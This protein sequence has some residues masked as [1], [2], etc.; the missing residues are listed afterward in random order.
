MER[1]CAAKAVPHPDGTDETAGRAPWA[2]YG[3]AIVI[4]AA[5]AG[6]ARL[7]SLLF[8]EPTNLVMVFLLAVT[9]TATRHGAGPSVLAALLGVAVFDFFF[10][11]PH[12]TFA[13]KDTQY[14]FTFLVLLIVGL[15]ISRLTAQVRREAAVAQRA[16]IEAEG[17]RLRSSLLASVSHDLRTPL[18]TIAGSAE[19][20]LQ[21]GP[22]AGDQ[23]EL[24]A[25]IRDEAQRLSRYVEKLIAMTR[26]E[27]GSVALKKEWQPIE[28]AIGAAI[29]RVDRELGHREV[30]TDVPSE[31]PLVAIDAPLIEQVIV[32]LLENACR[33][34]GPDAGILI[35]ARAEAG[36]IVVEVAD[37]GQGLPPGSERRV[38]E[39]FHRE[40]GAGSGAGLGLAICM[41]VVLAHG[42]TMW[43]A[44]RLDGGASFSFVLPL[45]GTPPRMPA[46][47]EDQ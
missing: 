36:G 46:P 37:S 17:E 8:V 16:A 45:G 23:S 44:N 35:R 31:L 28:D 25:S 12:L 2:G 43:A 18:A 19:A 41:A 33:H 26:L 7:L 15:V 10:V 22:L 9:Y 30:R 47:E 4:V 3:W 14:V 27:A 20:L 32:N 34:S 24:A 40:P 42:G 39:K 21:V 38:F 5:A 6:A 1:S 11:E 13:V 29:A